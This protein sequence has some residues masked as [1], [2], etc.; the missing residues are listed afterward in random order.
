M[1][2][3]QLSTKQINELEQQITQLLK[4]MRVAKLSTLPVYA[5]IQA[6][7]NE[8]AEIRRKRFDNNNSEYAG[9]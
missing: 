9:Y 4:L 3:D 2:T 5:D 6:L 8:L 7:E 1:E